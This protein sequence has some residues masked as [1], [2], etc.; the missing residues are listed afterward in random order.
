MDNLYYLLT[1][2]GLE[3]DYPNCIGHGD[4]STCDNRKRIEYIIDR[5]NSL[6]IESTMLD[7]IH[8]DK[9]VP[10]KTMV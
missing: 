7:A 10:L 2:C 8:P 3:N 5:Y 1:K 9:F 4:C 6:N